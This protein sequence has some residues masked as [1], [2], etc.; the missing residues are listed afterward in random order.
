MLAAD[1]LSKVW[2]VSAL[3]EREAV[4]VAGEA[5]QWM[6]VY[7]PGAAFS[8]GEGVTWIF[9]IALAAVAVAIVFLAVTRV[10]ARLWATVLGLLLGGVLGNLADRLLREPGFGH[11]HVVDFILTPWMWFWTNPAIYNVADIFIVGGMICVALLVL[12][13]VEFDGSRGSAKKAEGSAAEERAD[14]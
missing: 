9:T 14:G 5:L 13:G 1:Q 6:L 12:I 10:R 4:P 2:A 11:G 7:N 8:M 3:V